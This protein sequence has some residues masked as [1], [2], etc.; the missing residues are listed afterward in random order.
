MDLTAR[1]SIAASVRRAAA[2]LG[3]AA[4]AVEVEDFKKLLAQWEAGTISGSLLRPGDPLPS[5]Q[6]GAF[7]PPHP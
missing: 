3:A 5:R 1:K 7:P 4:S 2:H 6:Q